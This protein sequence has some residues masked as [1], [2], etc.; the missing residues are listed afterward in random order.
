MYYRE[1]ILWQKAMEAA[2]EIYRL[3]PR[4]PSTEN[5]GMRSQ[6]TRAAVSIPANIAEGWTRETLKD[7]AHFLAIA[8][9][10]LAETETLLTL[11]E[12]LGWFP[13]SETKKFRGLLDEVSRIL[14]TM[15][16][17]LRSKT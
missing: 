11:C 8:Q 14:T 2:R 7:K 13:K 10:S 15:R 6:I 5:Y 1:T 9:G 16:R 4:L 17:N 3:T 12:D